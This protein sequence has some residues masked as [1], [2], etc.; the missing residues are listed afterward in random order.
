TSGARFEDDV[1]LMIKEQHKFLIINPPPV[2]TCNLVDIGGNVIQTLDKDGKIR[3]LEEPRPN[4]EY[5]LCIDG[6]GTGTE[7]GEEEGSS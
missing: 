7:H 1:S 2:K 4:V 3:I 6:V 5:H